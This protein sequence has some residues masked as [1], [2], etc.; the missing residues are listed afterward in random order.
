MT[1]AFIIREISKLPWPGRLLV[2]EKTLKS[3]R[4]DKQRSLAAAVDLLGEDYASD[5]D[6]TAF[7]QLDA[8]DFYEAR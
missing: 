8:D 2:V 6:L 3:I 7:T 1:T 5:A 4:Q